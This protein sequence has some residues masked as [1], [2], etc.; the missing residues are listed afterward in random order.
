MPGRGTEFRTDFTGKD[1]GFQKTADRVNASGKRVGKTMQATNRK[2]RGAEKDGKAGARGILEASR[3]FED[4]QYGVRGVLNNIPGMVMGFG[5]TAAAAGALSFAA[6]GLDLAFRTFGKSS[7]KTAE[8]VEDGAEAMK[9][10]MEAAAESMKEDIETTTAAW[11]KFS[12]AAA[13][14]ADALATQQSVEAKRLS[15]AHEMA[16]LKIEED[17]IGGR[18]SDREAHDLT[19][20]ERRK[21]AKELFDAERDENITSMSAQRKKTGNKSEEL[22]NAKFRQADLKAEADELLSTAARARQIAGNPNRMGSARFAA[23]RVAK[24]AEA[25][26]KLKIIE[27][28]E[29]GKDTE[30]IKLE[31]AASENDLKKAGLASI[32]KD[33]VS[34][35][36]YEL[37]LARIGMDKFKDNDKDKI[38]DR[39]PSFYTW[40]GGGNGSSSNPLEGLGPA[41]LSSTSSLVGGSKPRA[42]KGL[43]RLADLQTKQNTAVFSSLDEL[44]KITREL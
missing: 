38:G 33:D 44:K 30:R 25:E 35:G 37:E 2:L 15:M 39:L 10:A 19:I 32:E 9:A 42:F 6:V 31:L 22:V 18:I 43:D 28:E 34:K 17:R 11:D 27:L 40:R 24:K 36:K 16:K 5:G 14:A 41:G 23:E 7:K 8:E 3:A 21:H 4:L 1:T 26:L 20:A 13:R 29:A 12:S